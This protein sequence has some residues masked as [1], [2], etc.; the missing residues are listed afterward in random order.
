MTAYNVVKFLHV[1]GAIGYFVA[2][3]TWLLTLAALRR[4]QRVEQVRTLTSLVG[5]LA[6]LFG[7][8]ILVI[9]VAGLYMTFAV[10]GFQAAWIDVALVTLL[11]MFPIA[12]RLVESR[13]GAIARMA[14]EAPDGPVPDTIAQRTHDP[15]LLTTQVTV[16]CLLLGIEFLMTNKPPT[17]IGSLIVIAIALALGLTT[18]WLVTRLARSRGKAKGT[19]ATSVGEGAG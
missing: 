8:S 19:Q 13:R 11:L 3:G 7:V 18:S 1:V 2:M 12:A 10:W 14:Q 16:T 6:A 9:L 4:A 5:G 15:A 17:L